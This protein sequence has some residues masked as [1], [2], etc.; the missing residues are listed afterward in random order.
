MKNDMSL[1]YKLQ[2]QLITS[3]AGR[4]LAIRNI[5][6]NTGGKTSGVDNIIWETPADRFNAIKL[7]WE[8]V[9]KPKLYVASPLKRVM[10]PKNNSNEKRTLSIP[11]MKDRAIQALYYLAVD[12][13][14]ETRSDN[15]SYGFRKGRSQHDAIAYIRSWLVKP[16]SPKL[17]LETDISKCFDKISHNYLLKN[18]PICDKTILNQWLKCGYIFEGKLYPTNEGTPQGG[19]ISPMLCN[20]TLNGL[21]NLIRNKFPYNKTKKDGRAKTYICIFADDIIVTGINKENLTV[22]K[23]SISAFL[24]ERGLTI[25][26]AK[27]RIVTIEEGFDYLGFNISRKK[28]N[29]RLNQKTDQKSVLIIKPSQ[30]SI[31][32]FVTKMK[33]II[34]TNNQM[35]VLIKELNPLIR[36]WAN[37]F[38][39]YLIILKLFFIKLGNIFWGTMMAWVKRKHPVGSQRRN[40]SK[41]MVSGLTRSKHKWVWGIQSPIKDKENKL[42]IINMAEI[43]LI[44]HTL[45]KLDKNPYLLENA[46]YFEKRSVQRNEAKFRQVIYNKFNHKCPICLESLH[47]GENIELHHIKPVK[48]GGEYKL[49]NIQAL[50]QICH[51]SIIHSSRNTKEM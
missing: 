44:K 39:S 22:A 21:E 7:L 29:A 26:E 35:V 1:V 15:Y 6:T 3:F 2:I 51:Q 34:Q 11:T 31:T 19:I 46:E 25:K 5:V 50:H 36:G 8:I 4:A 18:I 20:A 23:D 42:T 41:Y 16:Y 38:S 33:D 14:V 9:N 24:K 40:V 47:N 49:N 10:I 12:P 30:K 17:I 32:S 43:S 45:L 48:E 27:T 37:Y 13:V 28:F